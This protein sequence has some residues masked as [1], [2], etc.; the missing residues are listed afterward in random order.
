MRSAPASSVLCNWIILTMAVTAEAMFRQ[1]DFIR[2]QKLKTER[3]LKAR[4]AA[5][6]IGL[7][8]RPSL[9]A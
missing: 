8:L 1:L 7:N 3:H 5:A 4:L 6:G 2:T 9:W